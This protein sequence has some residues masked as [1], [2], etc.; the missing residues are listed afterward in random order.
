[1]AEFLY[2]SEG[3]VLRAG[4]GHALLYM[5]KGTGREIPID[6][7]KFEIEG[8]RTRVAPDGLRAA[9][10]RF[11]NEDIEEVILEGGTGEGLTLTMTLRLCTRTPFL[12]FRYALSSKVPA[13]LTKTDGDRLTYLSWETEKGADLT[14]IRFAVY[15]D[16]THGYTLKELPAFQHEKEIPGPILTE[17]R[18]EI[19]LFAGYEHG[20]M[21]PNVFIAF[22]KE[23]DRIG[24]RAVKGNY[25]PGHDLSSRPYETVWLQFGAVRG[26]RDD[27][28][29]AYRAYQLS[30]CSLNRESR[31]PH[32][33]YNTWAYQE[34]VK[35][36]GHQYLSFMDQ[37][38]MEREIS[39]AAKMGVDVFVIDTGWY[40]KTGDWL[41]NRRRFPDGIEHL[42]DLL[43]KH[44]MKLG[45][46]FAPMKAAVSS[47]IL[48]RHPDA[49]QQRGDEP[50][51][52]NPVWETEESFDM[53]PVSDYWEDFADRLIY[54]AKTVGVR[55]FKWDAVEMAGCDSPLHDH[56]DGTVPAGERRDNYSFQVGLYM[57][58]I[59]DRVCEAVPDAI[60]DMDITEGHRYFGLGFLS[61]GKFFSMNNGPYYWSYDIELPRDKWTNIFVNPGPARSW[62]VRQNLSYD[63]WI[64]SVLMLAHYLPDDPESSQL[65]NLASLVL[66]QNGIWGDLPGVSEEGADLFG[67]VLAEYKK[68]RDDV[69]RAYPV[70]Y[71]RP[72]ETFEVHEKISE[73]TGRGLISLF[74][75]FR[76][77]YRYR[78]GTKP[79]G[80]PVIFGPAALRR[81]EDGVW[82]DLEADGACAA[83]LFFE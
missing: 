2:E 9:G 58:K 34:R 62:I 18:E 22:E 55:Y 78:V 3:Y 16:I 24:I 33:Y 36:Q 48:A 74:A 79:A 56:G 60:V 23:E 51:K 37:E 63:R 17:E 21:F 75:N 28:A 13:R 39:R 42:R 29:K 64:P 19:S 31:K 26:S 53:C 59:A 30:F 6:W 66:G 80:D 82:I 73:E 44:G 46:W 52:A 83:V 43:A 45:L 32:I 68:V 27:L 35:F 25:L 71:G 20:S 4:G 14:E 5:P 61:S 69:T 65:I 77:T 54:L 15:D 7:P 11:L 47:G 67:R 57:S 70:V 72:G 38:R 12:R 10:R 41:G 50:P 49:K 40:E 76:G 8:K 1:M 81:E